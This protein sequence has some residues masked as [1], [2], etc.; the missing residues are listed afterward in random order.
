[1]FEAA[2]TA[3]E[4]TSGRSHNYLLH[5]AR[6]AYEDFEGEPAVDLDAVDILTVHQAKGLEWPIVFLPSLDAGPLSFRRAGQPR[7]GYCP[8][9]VF[10][11]TTAAATRA[12]TRRSAAC[13]TSR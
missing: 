12:A 2:R 4:P 7:S 8:K 9:Q 3:G 10:P 11:R 6:D 5:Y 13:S 1:M